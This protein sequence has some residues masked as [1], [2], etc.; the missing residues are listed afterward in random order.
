MTIVA[1]C[2][3]SA[4]MMTATMR[5]AALHRDHKA[6]TRQTRAISKQ[7]QQDYLS[8]YNTGAI[9]LGNVPWL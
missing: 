3:A 6:V 5:S 1:P 7:K 9:S 4:A 2:N 8:R